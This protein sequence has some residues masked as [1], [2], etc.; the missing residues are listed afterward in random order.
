MRIR[1]VLVIG[2]LAGLLAASS[3]A[4]GGDRIPAATAIGDDAITVAS[5]NFSES[6]LIA[7]IY[8]NAL[9]GA[10]FTVDRQIA[11]GTRELV[12]PSIERGL[13]EIVPEYAGSAVS[14]LGGTPSSDTA[15]TVDALRG[16]LD[17]RGIEV[18]RPS[19]AQDA[20]G[21]VVTRDTADRLALRTIGD[22]VPYAKQMTLGGP[23]ECPDRDLCL[24]GLEHRYGLRF[25]SF[26]A[27]DAGGPVTAEAIRR[28]T[29]D[30]GVL[31]TTDGALTT[32]DLVLLEDDRG[33]QPSENIVPIVRRDAIERFGPTITATLDRV[34]SLL[35]T[36][37]LR[38]LNVMIAND[39]DPSAA[40]RAWL[41]ANGIPGGQA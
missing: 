20:N 34:S 5:F 8:A 6:E 16:I 31:F 41:D 28:G 7:E 32:N 13:V 26:L 35:T 15:D 27:L 19:E 39:T 40:A 21:L 33:L 36:D 9:E 4:C 17:A 25:G 14:F 38:R 1:T 37:D 10:G 23:P 2:L 12:L 3:A 30:A 29:V 18:L 11:V 22:L 24:L